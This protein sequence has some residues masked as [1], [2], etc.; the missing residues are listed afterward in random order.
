MICL[1]QSN[2]PS[3]LILNSQCAVLVTENWMCRPKFITDSYWQTCAIQIVYNS[4]LAE[5]CIAH[6]V[7]PRLPGMSYWGQI[8]LHAVSWAKSSQPY[9]SLYAN[10]KRGFG[11]QQT[12]DFQNCWEKISLFVPVWIEVWEGQWIGESSLAESGSWPGRTWRRA[13]FPIVLKVPITVEWFTQYL[14]TLEWWWD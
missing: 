7:V 10:R 3:F 6:C 2:C 5:P 12:S 13:N 11:F 1:R 4:S 8:S 9:G 14:C